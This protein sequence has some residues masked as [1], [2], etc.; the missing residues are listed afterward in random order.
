MGDQKQAGQRGRSCHAHEKYAQSFMK[1][2]TICAVSVVLLL[3]L[4]L[5][6]KAVMVTPRDL[7]V[8]STEKPTPSLHQKKHATKLLAKHAVRP[9][10]LRKGSLF[11]QKPKVAHKV[12]MKQYV[13]SLKKNAVK[14][15]PAHHS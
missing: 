7:N 9:Q 1:K 11:H 4:G 12:T 14:K 10:K 3:S 8:K 15:P 2:L 13:A 5:P 6:A